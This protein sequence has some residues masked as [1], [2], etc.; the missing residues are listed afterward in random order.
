MIQISERL[1]EYDDLSHDDHVWDVLP[2]AQV[3]NVDASFF[4][5]FV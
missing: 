2:L 5:W 3:R 4:S 1:R